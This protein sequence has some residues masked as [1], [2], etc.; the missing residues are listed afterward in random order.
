MLQQQ[1]IAH[2]QQL[3]QETATI[4]AV[5]MYGSFTQGCGDQYSDV[6]FYVFIDDDSYQIFDKLSWVRQIRDYYLH[7]VNEYGTDVFIFAGL[8]RGEFHFL[9]ASQ[10]DIVPT[11]AMVGYIPDPDAM[12][13]YDRYGHLGEQLKTLHGVAPQWRS[14]DQISSLVGNFLNMT[15]YGINVLKR[16]ETVRSLECLFFAQRY[17]L[18][19][20]R[21]QEDTID[22]WLNPAK[23]LEQEISPTSYQLYQQCTAPL[24]EA[25]IYL[26]YS[27]VLTTGRQLAKQLHERYHMAYTP[28]LFD[29]LL[30][31]LHSAV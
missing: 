25:A 21:L 22:H 11:F 5:L 18:Q 6:E 14:P 8:I 15:L 30:D 16:G 27:A 19:L 10:M 28:M 31:Y 1:I 12:C 23:N 7:C 17:C 20:I 29:Q 9:P 13:L 3:A 24:D 2:T 26:A 4:E